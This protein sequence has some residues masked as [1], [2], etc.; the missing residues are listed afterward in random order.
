VLALFVESKQHVAHPRVE[1]LSDKGNK[2]AEDES[3]DGDEEDEEEQTEQVEEEEIASSAGDVG[4]NDDEEPEASET[5]YTEPKLTQD[6]EGLQEDTRRTRAS[7]SV[8]L[9]GGVSKPHD[10]LRAGES[11]SVQSTASSAV[12]IS[13]D[14]VVSAPNRG[15]NHETETGQVISN[16]LVAIG[17]N[18]TEEQAEHMDLNSNQRDAVEGARSHQSGGV[19]DEDEIVVANVLQ[20]GPSSNDSVVDPRTKDRPDMDDRVD[21]LTDAYDSSTENEDDFDDID[22]TDKTTND[23]RP[24]AKR[25]SGAD[26]SVPETP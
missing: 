9:A 2:D 14:N 3:F 8:R 15:S 17:A 20:R 13:H 18:A 10:V 22:P 19:C 6:E 23:F 4:V 11:V 25:A 1:V 26:F 21:S 24:R 16:D 5:F 7:S 12:S